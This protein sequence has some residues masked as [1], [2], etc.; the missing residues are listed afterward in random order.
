M[1][2]PATTAR[3]AGLLYLVIIVCGISGG[4]LRAETGVPD[5]GAMPAFRLGIV[6][7]LVM[8]LADVGVGVLLFFLLAPVSRVLSAMAMAFRL[9]QA[10]I[11]GLNLLNLVLAAELAARGDALAATFLSAHA[12]GY[13]LGLAFFAV[14]CILTAVLLVRA[15]F[16]PNA[17]GAMIGLSGLIYLTGSL[18]RVAAPALAEAFAPAYGAAFVAE[19]AFCLYLTSRGFGS[20]RRRDLRQA[21]RRTGT[22]ETAPRLA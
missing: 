14:N 6:M 22:Q 8:A 5:A 12:A 21:E 11:L 2:N 19:L 3:N 9:A 1:V 7:D 13:D 18:L 10:S 4:V 20:A 17:L 16:M 15:G